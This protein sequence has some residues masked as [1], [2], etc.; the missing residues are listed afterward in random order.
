MSD[1]KSINLLELEPGIRVILSD[2]AT[3]EIVDNPRDGMW[4]ICRYLSHPSDPS[5]VTGSERPVFA[6][7][8]V[9]AG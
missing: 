9:G 5:L 1:S 8:I 2:G 7:D 4:V 3:A 6:Q